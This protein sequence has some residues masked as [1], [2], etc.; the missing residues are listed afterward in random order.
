MYRHVLEQLPD[1]PEDDNFNNL[2]HY[3]AS[4]LYNASPNQEDHDA[5]I[6]CWKDLLSTLR[7][8]EGSTGSVDLNA[9][10]AI[11]Q[12]NLCKALMNEAISETS[13]HPSEQAAKYTGQ[14]KAIVTE[15]EYSLPQLI[16]TPQDPRIA[17]ARLLTM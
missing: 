14:L 1:A 15:D 10:P 16:N 3:Y 9:L 13:G 11:I 4:V 2:Y 6:E 5:A 7:S 12:K 17:L 8:R